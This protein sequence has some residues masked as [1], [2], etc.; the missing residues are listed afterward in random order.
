MEQLNY[1]DT[2]MLI[3]NSFTTIL[4]DAI[5]FFP[6]ESKKYKAESHGLLFG[7]LNNEVLECD[8]LFPVGNVTYRKEDEVMTNLK[9]DSAIQNAKHLLFT[10][11]CYGDYHSH[12]NLKSFEGW[13]EPSNGDVLY[14]KNLKLPYMLIIALTRNSL[15][16]K[17]L[18]VNY[19]TTTCKEY[20][21]IKKSGCHDF[22]SQK[23]S[24]NEVVYLQGVFKKYKFELRAFKYDNKC[25]SAVN[26]IS[27]EA[28][29]LMELIKNDINVK[30]LD[31]ESTYK[32]RKIE[33]DFR[34]LNL[35]EDNNKQKA[36]QN[37][38]HHIQKIKSEL[39]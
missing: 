31:S 23:I 27:S 39:I 38:Q 22:P 35:K 16:E 37:M 7:N 9:I 17:S 29:M 34:V 28:E 4:L 18:S 3:Q 26:L 6:Q 11:K 33:Y 1:P 25:L 12:P 24:D 30:D 20:F 10:S 14:A 19:A 32:L 36:L 5:Q 15:F 8:Y 13:S 21:Y 2:I